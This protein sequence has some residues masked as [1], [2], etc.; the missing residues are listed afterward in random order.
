MHGE[1][2]KDKRWTW[3]RRKTKDGRK[4]RK[5]DGWT[6]KEDRQEFFME[7]DKRRTLL[8]TFL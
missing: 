7:K 4:E 2:E 5:D 3:K 8:Y 1:K 6:G